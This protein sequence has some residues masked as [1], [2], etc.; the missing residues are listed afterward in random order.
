MDAAIARRDDLIRWAFVVVSVAVF[1][2]YPLLRGDGRD[3][4][5][6]FIIIAAIPAVA[7][8]LVRVERGHRL[9]W[10]L[11]LAGLAVLA[12]ANIVLFVPGDDALAASRLLDAVGNAL[13][14]AAALALVV[15]RGRDDLGGIIDASIV[16]FAVGGIL[17]DVVIVP[18][19]QPRPEGRSAEV[20]FFVAIFALSGVLGALMRLAQ[21]GG[22]SQ[23]ALWWLGA[24]LAFALGGNVAQAL[25]DDTW[26]GTLAQM[27]FIVT[28]ATL[29]LFGLDPS[30]PQ[31][32]RR[33]S[34]PHYDS[35]TP[36]RL[37]YLGV[38]VAVIPLVAGTRALLGGHTDGLLLTVGGGCIAALVMLRIGLLSSARTRAESAL[39]FQASHDPL[40]GLA[41]RRE[42]A[43]RL[44]DELAMPADC[45]IIFCDLDG[46]K[47]INDRLGHAVGDELLIEVAERLRVS[48]RKGDLVSRFGGD[49]FLILL[50]GA[51]LSQA[52]AICVRIIDELS[53]PFL[54]SDGVVTMGASMGLAIADTEQ[55]PEAL[56]QR[57]DHAM[58]VA[59]REE[60]GS[61]GIRII[62]A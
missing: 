17:W 14:L 6:A 51:V 47:S 28:Y 30:A 27:M 42:F 9:P 5:F 56:I 60:P 11:L 10:W 4:V 26:V 57:A 45:V 33:G 38:A 54:L 31:L 3:A 36:G 12:I 58:Y 19:L 21:V 7:V 34:W 13:A 32:V 2:A 49:E 52:E 8:G 61:P 20:D 48:V 43:A 41:N 24:G 55:D 15:R 37:V 25:G 53:Q 50:R 62:R 40:T 16:A 23:R 35:L 29:G 39:R 59:K 46:F 18:L 44:G 22:R 1:V